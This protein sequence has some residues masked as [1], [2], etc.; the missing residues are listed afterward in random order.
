MKEKIHT[1]LEDLLPL[2]DLES[3]FLFS[4]LDSLGVT[5][6]L[7]TLSDEFGIKLEYKDA[8]PK[9]LKN[10]DNIVAMVEQKL[11]EKG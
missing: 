6:I 10:L 8:T 4:E 5:T 1:L 11:S 7:M 2:V 9:N 3:D